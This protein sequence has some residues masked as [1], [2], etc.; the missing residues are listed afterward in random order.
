MK[1]E[2]DLDVPEGII[3]ENFEKVVREDAILRLFANRKIPAGHATRLLGLTRM[4]FM[5]FIQS[6]S[7]PYV[8]YTNEDWD[9]DRKAI[10]EYKRRRQ[11]R[12]SGE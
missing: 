10:E 6:R 12:G 8:E 9:A 2:I 7:I 5:D 1:L 3:D 4:Q 11:L